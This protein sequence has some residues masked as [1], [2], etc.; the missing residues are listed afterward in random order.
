MRHKAYNQIDVLQLQDRIQRAIVEAE[1]KG[2]VQCS[3]S[4]ANRYSVQDSLAPFRELGYEVSVH[5]REGVLGQNLVRLPLTD[6][7]IR[8]ERV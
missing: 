8:W 5:Q 7:L 3:V 4:T 1:M 2:M 6:I